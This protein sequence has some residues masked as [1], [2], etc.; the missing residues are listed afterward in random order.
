MVGPVPGGSGGPRGNPCPWIT[1]TEVENQKESRGLLASAR[2][3]QMRVK[4]IPRRRSANLR[5]E[6]QGTLKLRNA[7]T[8]DA[9]LGKRRTNSWSGT[10]LYIFSNL[11]FAAFATDLAGFLSNRGLHM[12]QQ[13]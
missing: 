1:G 6:N 7:W 3:D 4:G 11:P 5:R 10:G 2:A 8:R 12:P 13:K 9:E